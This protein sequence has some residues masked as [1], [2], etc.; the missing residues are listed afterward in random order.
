MGRIDAWSCWHQQQPCWGSWVPECLVACLLHALFQSNCVTL[1]IQYMLLL[2]LTL[3]CLCS[4][5][6]HAGGYGSPGL[7][8][9]ELWALWQTKSSWVGPGSLTRWA[10]CF[11]PKDK[12]WQGM[13]SINTRTPLKLFGYA[14]FVLTKQQGRPAWVGLDHDSHTWRW[15]CM[16]HGHARSCTAKKWLF[17]MQVG[18]KTRCCMTLLYCYDQTPA[19]CCHM[20][21]IL[22]YV[23]CV[24]WC[25]KLVTRVLSCHVNLHLKNQLQKKE[26]THVS[27]SYIFHSHVRIACSR[28]AWS[29]VR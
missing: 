8:P 9:G 20:Q 25:Q 29:H 2:P 16:R 4:M 22:R 14:S 27:D 12:A 24:R 23:A 1:A 13:T 17:A 5:C 28:Q 21:H 11:L 10:T 7:E 15:V 26:N 18:H 19:T 6:W 3:F